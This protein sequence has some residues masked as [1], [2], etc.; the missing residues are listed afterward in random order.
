MPIPAYCACLRSSVLSKSVDAYVGYLQR[1]QYRPAVIRIY[2]RGVEHFARWV[3]RRRVPLRSI[4]ESLTHQFLTEH[5][6]ACRCP[7]RCLRTFIA[8]RAALVHLL[9]V[10]RIE[11]YI[12]DSSE[13]IV[14][15][16]RFRE[17]CK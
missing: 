10:L 1:Q 14:G 9:H 3:T 4:D 16:W 6:P 15:E 5:L 11:G 7:G 12:S 2:L 8:V 17:F 13:E